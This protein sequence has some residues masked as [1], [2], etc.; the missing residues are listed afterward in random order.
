VLGLLHGPSELL[1]IS[2]SAHTSLVSWLAGWPYDK[3]DPQLR[4]SFEVALHA[5]TAT[6]LLVR[7]PWPG[8]LSGLRQSGPADAGQ[9]ASSR[10]RVG[11]RLCFL[12]GALT[13]PA[14]A[15]Y[16]LGD[17][18]ERRLGT[19]ATIAA[20][21]IAGSVAV[22]AAEVYARR[23]SFAR[24]RARARRAPLFEAHTTTPQG[25][26]TPAPARRTRTLA[27]A[28]R[29]DGLALGLAQSLALFPGVSRSGATIAAARARG[30][31]RSDADRLSWRVGLPVI[32][33]ATAL[34]S[35]QLAGAGLPREL[36]LPLA[37]GAAS[38]LL[39]TFA[40][41]AVLTPRRRAGLLPA[42]AAYRAVL[43]LLVIRRMR[44]NTSQH[45]PKSLKK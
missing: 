42:C 25:D 19:P 4:K 5:G 33:G 34:K 29:S 20:G 14:L 21:L 6:A 27:S 45:A 30:F 1:P 7:P 12:A 41:A 22:T 2:S 44:D 31:S 3:L 24:V 9:R 8:S 13:P 18:V 43:A 37:V 35:T 10:P 38:A 32:A 40:S 36:R 39:S 28:G 15:G 11:A 16:T 23:G 26:G 17:Q